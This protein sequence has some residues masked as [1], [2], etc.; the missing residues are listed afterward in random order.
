SLD[1]TLGSRAYCYLGDFVRGCRDRLL[2]SHVSWKKIDAQ[3]R[4]EKMPCQ[5]ILMNSTRSLRP[6]QSA[7]YVTR[8]NL[9]TA[10]SI[11]TVT[12]PIGG[13]SCAGYAVPVLSCPRVN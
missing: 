11:R 7:P 12:I 3:R 4:G 10:Q 2:H 8:W 13:S 5:T 9:R 1:H 6:R